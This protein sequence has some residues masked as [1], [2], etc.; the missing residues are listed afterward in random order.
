MEI[1]TRKNTFQ[2]L[3]ARQVVKWMMKIILIVREN[4]ESHTATQMSQIELK[5]PHNIRC[6]SKYCDNISEE[7][8]RRKKM[9]EKK[10][11]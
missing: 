2:P 9:K 10:S 6:Q 1:Y 7:A 4:N 3:A 8:K 5:L 11:H